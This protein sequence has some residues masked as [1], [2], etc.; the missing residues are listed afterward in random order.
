MIVYIQTTLKP[1]ALIIL[2]VSVLLGEGVTSRPLRK[3]I[4]NTIG[5]I[6]E[7]N[8]KFYSLFYCQFFRHL[9]HYLLSL[10]LGKWFEPR[11]LSRLGGSIVRLRVAPR[12]TVV[13][14][15]DRRL[16][17]LSGSHHHSHVNC[18]SSVYGIYVSGQLSRICYW[19]F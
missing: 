15:I 19:L 2:V 14:D 17:N 6:R 3:P 11:S 7:I 1:C 18:V 16:D 4:Q 10:I 5:N 12:R 13:G 9:Y 8:L